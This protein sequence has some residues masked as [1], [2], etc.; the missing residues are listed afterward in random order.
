MREPALI[1]D[2]GNVVAFFD[3]QKACDRL[4]ARMGISGQ[5]VRERLL[6]AGFPALLEQLE[7]G[8]IMPSAFAERVLGLCGASASYEDFVRDWEDI[9]SLNEPVAQL[10]R[11]LKSRGYVLVLGSNTNVLHATHYRRR[12]A[13]TLG[14]FD[15]LILSYEVGCLK[16]ESR[17]YE[18]CVVAAGMPAS[19]CVFVDDMPENVEGARRAGLMA[20]RYVGTPALVADLARLG[21]DILPG[22]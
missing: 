11:R 13:A 8:Q 16:P 19:S 14:L 18:A 5:A 12:F 6:E 21:V 7:L 3:Y 20:L 9:F 17:F 22:E 4:G 2:F 15:D 10:V 1:F